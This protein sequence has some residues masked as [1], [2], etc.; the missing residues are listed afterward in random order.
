MLYFCWYKN[1]IMINKKTKQKTIF[2]IKI[3]RGQKGN[4]KAYN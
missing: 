1:A 2:N 3:N 4:K